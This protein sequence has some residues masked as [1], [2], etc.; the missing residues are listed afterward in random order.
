MHW[1]QPDPYYQRTEDGYTV[2]RAGPP[3]NRTYSAWAPRLTPS[4][5]HLL[6]VYPTSAQ[7]R[8]ECERHRDEMQAHER[9]AE[10]AAD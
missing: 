6:G 10:G 1:T 5:V 4:H 2:S 8:A 3:E 7:A 9:A